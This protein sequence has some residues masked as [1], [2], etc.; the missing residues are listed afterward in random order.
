MTHTA[1][2]IRILDEGSQQEMAA[3]DIAS[4]QP[5]SPVIEDRA[6]LSGIAVDIPA[7]EADDRNEKGAD[8]TSEPV[9][10][11]AAPRFTLLIRAAKLVSPEGEFLC[12]IRDVSE[13]G[14]SVK[15]FHALPP[16]LPL[17][18]HMQSGIAYELEPVWNRDFEAGFKFSRSVDVDQL[19]GE[20]SEYPKR[21]LRLD[22]SFPITIKTLKGD[23]QGRIVNLS[24][25]GARIESDGLFALDQ[26]LRI[27]PATAMAEFRETRAKV[28]WRRDQSYG[29]VFDD[30]FALGDFAR[31]A[32][33]LQAPG[34][35]LNGL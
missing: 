19:I 23:A 26:T 2:S 17:E 1:G 34:L 16:G 12:V 6:E 9:D 20:A 28:R 7:S 18:L 13:T 8:P 22:L 21:G 29:A 5:A 15:L 25:Q 33:R 14:M 24:Q 4:A 31:L 11:R 35:L 10:H 27:A 30:T 32:A 3:G